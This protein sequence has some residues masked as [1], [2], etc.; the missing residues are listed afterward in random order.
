MADEVL[1]LYLTPTA[2]PLPAINVEV[3]S[4]EEARLLREGRPS[5]FIGPEEI[6]EIED[7]TD[8]LLDV[9][10]TKAPPRLRIVTARGR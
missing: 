2:I 5:D 9:L 1:A 4:T 6:A 3:S 10:R 7:R 8:R